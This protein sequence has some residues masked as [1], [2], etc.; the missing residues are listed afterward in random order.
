MMKRIYTFALLAAL[1]LAGCER[2]EQ[3]SDSPKRMVIDPTMVG[4]PLPTSRATETDFEQGDAIGLSVTTSGGERYASNARFLFDA[5]QGRF[6]SADGLLWYEDVNATSTLFACYPY[7]EGDALPASF[8]VAEDQNGG[9]YAASDLMTALKS[10]VRP[11][12]SAVGM[13]FRHRMARLI[14]N[15]DNRSGSPVDGIVVRN[16]VGRGLLDAADDTFRVDPDGA[17]VAVKARELT[18]DA[19][20]YVLLVPQS[21]RLEVEVTTAEGPRTYTLGEAEL[22]GG[23]NHTLNVRI[24]PAEMEVVLEDEITGWEDGDELFPEESLPGG[25]DGEEEG[26]LEYGGERY[27]TVTLADGRTWMAENLRYVPEGMSIS[28]DPSDGSG[29]WYPYQVADKAATALTD[30]ASV[31]KYG[32]LYTPAVAFGEEVSEANY[33]N[34]EGAQGICPEGWHIPSRSEWFALVGESNKADGED[35]K[36]ENDTDAPFF[37]AEAGY[38]TVVKADAC[39]FNFT[40]AGSVTGGKYSTVTV[41]DT[42]TSHEEWYGANAMNYVLASTGYTGSK[43]QMFS[44][45]S[46]FTK[47]F[48]EGKLSVAYTNL[49]NG[50]Q[51]RCVLDRQ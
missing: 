18:A 15:V 49:D 17:A 6:L 37:D 9:G 21:V 19:K 44:L 45:M 36:P 28:S 2:E 31:A 41:D 26:W 22:Q 46:S 35:S 14:V 24:L 27:R 39:G 11:T 32:L 40:F 47:T 30:D 33:K 43:P 42:K 29:L 48:P 13:T 20:Y 23:K 38:A 16:A 51:V 12:A 5:S 34:L 50:V 8:T 3:R 7:R 25:D 1:M 4:M 10:D